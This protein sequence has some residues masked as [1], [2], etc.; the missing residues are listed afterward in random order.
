MAETKPRALDTTGSPA[1]LHPDDRAL[2]EAVARGDETATREFIRRMQCVPRFVA[3]LRARSGAR[4]DEHET[5]DV[6]QTVLASLWR[7]IATFGGRG[8]LESWAYSYCVHELMNA[9]RRKRAE[10]ASALP[11]EDVAPPV[12]IAGTPLHDDVHRALERLG[13][14]E[15]AILRMKHFDGRTFE[16]IASRSAVPTNTIKTRYYRALAKVRELLEE[17]RREEAR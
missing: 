1:P 3:V 10:R 9:A 14:G 8:T 5:G 4:L 12:P 16:E 7:R 17:R 6:V 11:T 15:A 2:A 13:A